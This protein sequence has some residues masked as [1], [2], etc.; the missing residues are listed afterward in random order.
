MK[1]Y[2]YSGLIFAKSCEFTKPDA[3]KSDIWASETAGQAME[4]I[5]A[6]VKK[7]NGSSATIY[8]TAFNEVN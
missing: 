8:F 2:F 6:D 1:Q 4:E 7:R 3:S 5:I